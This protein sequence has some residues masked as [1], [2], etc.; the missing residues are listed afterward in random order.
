MFIK[1]PC[2]TE[3]FSIASR[4]IFASVYVARNVYTESEAQTGANIVVEPYVISCR[5]LWSVY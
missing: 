1:S 2:A 4:V 5:T 3:I